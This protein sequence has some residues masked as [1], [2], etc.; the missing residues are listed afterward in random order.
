MRGRCP[1]VQSPLTR[2]PRSDG[3]RGRGIFLNVSW[4]PGRCS[5]DRTKTQILPRIAA[6]ALLAAMQHSTREQWGACQG[7]QTRAALIGLLLAA[8][9][10]TLLRPLLPLGV[11]LAARIVGAMLVSIMR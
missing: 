11:R 1:G 6:Q 3:A 5:T 2:A 8:S 9:Y 4:L 7:D 10:C